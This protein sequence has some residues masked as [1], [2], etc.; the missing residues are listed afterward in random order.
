MDDGPAAGAQD[1]AEARSSGVTWTSTS[2]HQIRS[3]GPEAAGS[4]VARPAERGH[5]LVQQVRAI[6]TPASTAGW[7]R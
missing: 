7:W 1:P 3:T 4:S 6:C 2:R 5:Q